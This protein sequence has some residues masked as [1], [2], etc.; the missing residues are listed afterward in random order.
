MVNPAH[1]GSPMC[2]VA[3]PPVRETRETDFRRRLERA[4]YDP[5]SARRI[6]VRLDY[7]SCG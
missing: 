5:I 2:R 1:E 4:G 7:C 6:P 3:A